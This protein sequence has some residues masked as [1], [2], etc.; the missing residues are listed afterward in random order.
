MKNYKTIINEVS[1]VRKSYKEK[2]QGPAYPRG[3]SFFKLQDEERDEIRAKIREI[4]AINQKLDK[5]NADL[6]IKVK[7]LKHNIM[8]ALYEEVK[9]PLIDILNKYV[10]KQL[11]PKTYE[12]IMND[13]KN[14]TGCG[15]RIK[16]SY[17]Y[18]DIYIYLLNEDGCRSLEDYEI[19]IYFKDNNDC[20]SIVN[21]NNRLQTIDINTIRC[22]YNIN[23]YIE[24]INTYVREYK[25]IYKKAYKAAQAYNDIIEQYQKFKLYGVNMEDL[26]TCYCNKFWN[27]DKY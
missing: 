19:S 2:V 13:F 12:S 8:C 1:K 18:T 23:E 16:N 9:Q 27:I 21:N 26:R 4:D 6:D 22:N 3:A 5:Y 15:M 24:D 25:K 10:N 11:G 7:V 17:N 20:I 14:I